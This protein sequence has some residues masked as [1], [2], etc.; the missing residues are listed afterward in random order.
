[1][2]KKYLPQPRPATRDMSKE[3]YL[4]QPRPATRNMSKKHINPRTK[5]TLCFPQIFKCVPLV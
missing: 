4:P 5:E 1:L 2:L 3:E